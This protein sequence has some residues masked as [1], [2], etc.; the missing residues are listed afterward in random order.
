MRRTLPRGGGE[1]LRIR[2]AAVVHDETRLG[3]AL[4][5]SEALAEAVGRQIE[6]EA[7][8]QLPEE[9][10]ITHEGVGDGGK[11]GPHPFDVGTSFEP[12]DILPEAVRCGSSA[13]DRGAGRRVGAFA[14]LDDMPRFGELLARRDRDLHVHGL[15][16]GESLGGFPIVGGEEVAVQDG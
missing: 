5:E 15:E 14:D 7:H 16:H 6:V 4:D 10:Y 12:E 1:R 9:P 8:A 13:D 11:A 3:A 2:I